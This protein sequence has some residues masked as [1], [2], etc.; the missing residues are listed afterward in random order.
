MVWP[1][2]PLLGWIPFTVLLF[3]FLP[4]RKAASIAVIAGYLV[5]PFVKYVI[6]GLPDFSKDTAIALSVLLGVAIFDTSRWRSLRLKWYDLP[7]VCYCVVAMIMSRVA[8]GIDVY[9]G[10]SA[11]LDQILVYGVPYFVGRMYYF[12]LEGVRALALAFVIGG[13]AYVPLCLYEIKM[14]PRLN[15]DVYGIVNVGGGFAG[16]NIRWGGFR[17]S[18]LLPNGLTLSM[19]MT[20]TAVTAYWLWASGAVKTLFGYRFGWLTGLLVVTAVLCKSTGA[21]GLLFLGLGLYHVVKSKGSNWLLTVFLVLPILYMGTRATEIWSGRQLTDFTNDFISADR[22]AS[23]QFRF[24]QEN[25]L[26][27]KSLQKPVFGWAGWRFR[28]YD[29][30]GNDISVTDGYWVMVL[31]DAGLFGLTMFTLIHWLPQL[32]TYR[33][34]PPHH[35]RD[36]SVVPAAALSVTL[37][38]YLIDNLFNATFGPV[39][40]LFCGALMGTSSKSLVRLDNPVTTRETASV[41]LPERTALLLESNQVEAAEVLCRQIAER[42][43]VQATQAPNDPMVLRELAAA[44]NSLGAFLLATGRYQEAEDALIGA[45]SLHERLAAEPP[46]EPSRRQDLACS[47]NNLG[48]LSFLT[49]RAIEAEGLWRRALDLEAVLAAEHPGESS[50]RRALATGL[51]HLGKVLDAQGRSRESQEAR[52]SALESWARLARRHP[53]NPEFSKRWADG[54]NDLAWSL[55]RDAR[56]APSDAEA[57]VRFALDAVHLSPNHPTYRNTL[58][59]AYYRAGAWEAA[60]NALEIASSLNRGGTGF[61]LYFLAMAFSRLGR[62][63]QAE[64][65][66]LLADDWTTANQ[67]DHAELSRIRAESAGVRAAAGHA[68][69]GR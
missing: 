65:C 14:S 43:E 50:Y 45:V 18:G 24:D 16:D 36:P 59:V 5:V 21:I 60:V 1:S 67:P 8:N 44:R 38:L 39:T 9:E 33:R 17:P 68:L 22:A 47:L 28:V 61:D 62:D 11:S 48:H 12:D 52:R 54:S 15:A 58:G 2:I 46:R 13:A 56:T 4:P 3:S 34:Y 42:C 25:A 7:A 66:F 31:G 63:D 23:L 27:E 57:A 49:D 10:L 51:D 55:S 30:A 53:E 37:G 40:T 19:W 29:K 6:P 41:S 69:P 35:W 20:G 26:V 32:L 64:R